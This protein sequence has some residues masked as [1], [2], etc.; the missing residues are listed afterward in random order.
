VKKRKPEDMK[1]IFWGGR[2]RPAFQSKVLKIASSVA[3]IERSYSGNM[4]SSRETVRYRFLDGGISRSSGRFD[5]SSGVFISGNLC[6]QYIL[7]K[8]GFDPQALLDEGTEIHS[9]KDLSNQ[10]VNGTAPVKKNA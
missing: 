2:V 10:I 8:L 4:V 7:Y 9:L 6:L 1:N 3:K 5:A